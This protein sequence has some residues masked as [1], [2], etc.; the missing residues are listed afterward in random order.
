MG[1]YSESWFITPTKEPTVNSMLNATIADQKRQQYISDAETFRRARA[2]RPARVP[3]TKR[4]RPAGRG[5]VTRPLVA[6][7]TWLAAGYL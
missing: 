1:P 6:F 2:G 3:R 5:F 7:Q 4:T